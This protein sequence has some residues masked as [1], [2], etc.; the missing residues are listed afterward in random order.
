MNSKLLFAATVA[1][2]VVSSLAMADEAPVTRAQVKAELN[3]AIATHS[4]QT[5]YDT[6][7]VGFVAASQ[8]TRADVV[9]DIASSKAARKALVGPDRSATYNQ[10]GTEIL[11]QSTLTRAEVKNDVREAV[12]AGTLQRTDYDDATLSARRAKQHAASGK[13]AQRVK[14]V[15]SR[16]EG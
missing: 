8:R 6:T 2:S 16:A 15:F 7:G 9:A 11:K 10:F 14:A 3:Q 5:D 12:A 13:F 4:L 1:I